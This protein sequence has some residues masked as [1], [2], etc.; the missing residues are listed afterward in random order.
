MAGVSGGLP[1]T[2]GIAARGRVARDVGQENS[3]Y[4]VRNSG[5]AG[6]N[7]RDRGGTLGTYGAD[8]TGSVCE[9]GGIF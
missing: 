4:S 1:E 6:M 3:A 7:R 5:K 9:S 8:S 2:R